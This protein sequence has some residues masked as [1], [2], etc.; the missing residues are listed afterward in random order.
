MAG[1]D[2]R[3]LPAEQKLRQQ[4]QVFAPSDMSA[5]FHREHSQT[6]A[7]CNPKPVEGLCERIHKQE[8]P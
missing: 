4:L 6:Q 1:R 3:I 2:R 7:R 5:Q 8:L